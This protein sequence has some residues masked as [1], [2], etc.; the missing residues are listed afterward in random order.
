MLSQSQQTTRSKQ[1]IA[2]ADRDGLGLGIICQGGLAQLAADPALLVAAKW[3]GLVQHVVL[4]DPDGAGFER[5]GDADSGVEVLGVHGSG[6]AVGGG[7]A[8]ADRV[9][10]VFELRDR[11]HR[12]EDFFLHD[13]HL[14]ADVGEDGRLDEV[15]FL[16]VAFAA[17]L[18][19][20]AF[21]FAVLDVTGF[22]GENVL[23][24]KVR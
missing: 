22:L 17:H 18:E 16:T 3:Q 19:L 2:E 14:L 24:Y 15:A 5:A 10:F 20:G 23:E 7:V 13:L 12:A 11:A 21:V 1:G 4:V 9:G 6:E 8:E